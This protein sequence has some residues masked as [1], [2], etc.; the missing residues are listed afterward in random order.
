MSLIT[1]S[2]QDVAC[3]SQVIKTMI[4]D[5]GPDLDLVKEA[6]P[7]PLLPSSTVEL[8]FGWAACDMGQA[9][10]HARW[11]PLDLSTKVEVI[12]VSSSRS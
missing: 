5:L 11:D 1:F 4:D 7:I 10:W 2:E 8:V 12:W 9:G 3:R 6:I